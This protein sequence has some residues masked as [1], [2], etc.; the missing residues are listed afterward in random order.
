MNSLFWSDF[1]PNDPQTSS[2]RQDCVSLNPKAYD[3][4][5]YKENAFVCSYIQNHDEQFEDLCMKTTEHKCSCPDDQ[6]YDILID[7]DSVKV[8]P[9]TFNPGE[10]GLL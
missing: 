5:C 10:I 9:K 2:D 4:W 3:G 7:G 8:G 6:E 1:E